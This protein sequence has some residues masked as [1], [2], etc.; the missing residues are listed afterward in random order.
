LELSLDEYKT[1]TSLNVRQSIHLQYSEP[2][3]HLEETTINAAAL[4]PDNSVIDIGAGNGSFLR[5]LA[6]SGHNGMIVA[7]DRSMAA[8][9]SIATIGG[10]Y[11]LRGDACRLP[12]GDAVFDAVFAR[13]MLYHVSDVM[14]ALRE[15][16]RVLRVGGKCVTVVNHAEQA[17]RLSGLL[18]HR[19]EINGI[20]PPDLPQ[21]DSRFL[22]DMLRLVFSNTAVTKSHGNL[23]FSQPEPVIALGIA[24]LGFYGVAPDSPQRA[25]IEAELTDDIRHWFARSGE[26]WRDPK[27]F[28]VCVSIRSD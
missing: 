21:V 26:P 18:R 19:V 20:R 12:L 6:E 9:Q 17:P 11:S 24:L 2:P 23:V 13:H 3:D 25:D 15:F 10:P 4:A 16:K 28:V 22:P 5:R 1:L 8:A 27:G 7:L 14:A